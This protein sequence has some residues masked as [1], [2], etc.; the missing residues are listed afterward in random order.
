[1]KPYIEAELHDLIENIKATTDVR[2]LSFEEAY[3]LLKQKIKEKQ[4]PVEIYYNA[5]LLDPNSL[6]ILDVSELQKPIK[7]VF[8]DKP[9]AIKYL[10][11]G[12][13]TICL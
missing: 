12:W 3:L 2:E 4:I 5:E 1:M 6:W 10:E 9:S 13:R 11:E 7:V 8:E